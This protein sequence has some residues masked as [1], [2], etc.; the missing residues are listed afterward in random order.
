[1][2]NKTYIFIGAGSTISL[3][4]MR[5]LENSNIQIMAF[6]RQPNP[7]PGLS[8][9]RWF[10]GDFVSQGIPSDL[11]PEKAD[12]FVYFPGTINLRP[13]TSLSMEEFSKDMEINF[14][15]MVRTLKPFI[16]ALKKSGKASVVLFSTV[17]VERGMAYHSSIAASKAAVEGFARSLAAEYAPIIRVNCVAP[18]LTATALAEK[19]V[20][21]E[22]RKTALAQK[23]P[24]K[25]IGE[26][27]DI[28]SS[29]QFLLSENSSWI[30]GQVIAVDGGMST[31][32]IN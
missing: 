12:G 30:T 18:S 31:L 15:G 14:F 23:H 25:R 28:A 16:P 32:S 27:A 6:S 24:L 4:M 10:Q 29:V 3:E 8:N 13:F 26:P 19:L 21:N 1:M 7:F 9:L 22:E 11:I 20:S 17:A 5:T 2:E